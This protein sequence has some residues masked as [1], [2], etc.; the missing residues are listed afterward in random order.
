MNLATLKSQ[1]KTG[2]LDNIYVF[3]GSESEVMR[4]YLKKMAEVKDATLLIVDNADE[5]VKKSLTTS[6]LKSRHI[7]VL[8]ECKEYLSDD[9]FQS[10]LAQN[11]AFSDDIIVFIYAQIDKRSKLYKSGSDKIVEFDPLKSDIL[12][13]YIKKQIDLSEKNCKRLIEVCDSDY[14]RILLE[15]DKINICVRAYNQDKS[16]PGIRADEAFER[17]LM[18]G[19]VY[20]PP[21]DAVFDFVDAVLKYKINLSF[22]LLEESYASGE[23]TLVIIS[24]LFSS[25][26]QLLQYQSYKGNSMA[27]ATGLTPF[28]MKL[29]SGRKGYYTNGVLVHLLCRL[30]D[31]EK[32]IKTGAIEENMAVSYILT[33][34]WG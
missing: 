3:T 9:R 33:W 18:D 20:I 15:I 6:F 22:D 1:I 32:G 23:A 30:R 16:K 17:L 29:A 26:K 28:Q 12:I 34:L 7:Y 19:T 11:K 25:A 8:Y 24:N 21:Q 14:S 5:L 31:V 4:V 27:E 13:K 2:T 10:F